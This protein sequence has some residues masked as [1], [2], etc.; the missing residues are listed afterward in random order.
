[1][2]GLKNILYAVT[3]ILNENFEEDI[4]VE[5]NNTGGFENSCFFVQLIPVSTEVSTKITNLRSLIISIKYLQQAGESIINLLD[6]S[7]KLEKIFGRTLRADNRV[8]TIN[9]MENTIITDEVGRVLDFMIHIDFFDEKYIKYTGPNNLPDMD[10]TDIKKE[11]IK[12]YEEKYELMK[13]L[14]ADV[15]NVLMVTEYKEGDDK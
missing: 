11:T 8:I 5:D 10:D 4:Y 9:H 12:L 7:D 2:L 15:E 1:M 3:T 6:I 14:Y 13:K